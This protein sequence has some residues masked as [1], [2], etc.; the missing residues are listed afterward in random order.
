MRMC[1]T[2]D[3]LAR[4]LLTAVRAQRFERTED[5]LQGGAPVRHFP[6]LDLAVVAFRPDAPPVWADV[7]F[8]REHPQGLVAEIGADA[9]PLR[10]VRFEADQRD[11]AGSSIAWLPDA[12]WSRLALPHL[13]GSGPHRFVAPYPA[14]LVKL[15]VAI[16]VAR[17][18]DDGRAGWDEPVRHGSGTRTLAQW[19]EAMMVLS[20]NDATSA[21]VARLHRAGALAP[22]NQLH[23]LFARYGLP[24]LRLADTRP[25][26]GWRNID[27]A[28]VG[29]LQMTAWDTA[30]ALWLLDADAP[31][32]PWLEPGT[33]PLLAPESRARVRWWLDD[34]ARHEILSSTVL[35]GVRGWVQGLPARLPERWI[36]D[37]GSV[38]AG[39]RVYPADV[40]PASGAGTRRF[41]HKTGA[42]DNYASDAGIVRGQR[43]H[44]IVA[45]L[46]SLGRRY[47]PGSPCATTWRLPAL[48]RAIDALF[49]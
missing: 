45:L 38:V 5:S 13:W 29:H 35:A 16:G 42:T 33:P 17:A 40:R 18:V 41:A 48:G 10:N 14:S 32:A 43:C 12:D 30:R 36:V 27:G 11:A 46:T 20:D 34:Q 49:P 28:G 9:G 2:H 19:A 7:L 3:Q 22:T 31:A 23:A 44:Y 8:S 21:V 47:A 4:A 15:M 1:R 25:D 26:G 24:T 37:G 6:S 39:E